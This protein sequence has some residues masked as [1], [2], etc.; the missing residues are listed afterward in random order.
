MGG[1]QIGPRHAL[2]VVGGHGAPGVL[3]AEERAIVAEDALEEAELVG[4][5]AHGLEALDVLGPELALG[6]G[7]LVVRHGL[8]PQPL[9]HRVDALLEHGGRPLRP[10]L[11]VDPEEVGVDAP[12]VVRLDGGRHL[13]AADEVLV[14]P[15]ALA[16]REQPL[17]DVERR[18]VGVERPGRMIADHHSG[19][20]RVLPHH[21]PP[22]AVLR[23]L[24]RVDR[25][26][27]PPPRDRPE[28]ALDQPEGVLGVDVAREHEGGVVGRIVGLEVGARLVEGDV[29]DVGHEADDVP[30][31]G[32]LDEGL[33]VQRLVHHAP[34]LVVDAQAALLHDDA[35]L[36]LE[37]LLGDGEVRHPVALEVEHDGQ[38]LAREVVQ[39]RGVVARRVAVGGA[40]VSLDQVVENAGTEL[41]P[42]VEHH[43]LEEV[44]DAGGTAHLVARADVVENV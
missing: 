38:R 16:S 17:D 37:V 39:V 3:E 4:L 40:A 13:V 44:R 6:L 19:E 18:A 33:E 28:V 27:R 35:A 41:P 11:R 15:R 26:R 21:H 34:H 36:L 20:L 14:Q 31:V 30:A 23:R 5:A 1:H 42:A 43:V 22:L 8:R 29:L 12:G 2:D 9:D 10:G 24:G 32:A 7:E 25:E